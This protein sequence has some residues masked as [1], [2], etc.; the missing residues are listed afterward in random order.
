MSIWPHSF[1]YFKKKPKKVIFSR[2]KNGDTDLKLGMQLDS[3]NNMGGFHLAIPL[4]LYKA[5][6]AK[7]GTSK[8]HLDLGNYTHEL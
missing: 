3:S 2:K 8:E 1:L 5:R 4:P 6:N 7:N